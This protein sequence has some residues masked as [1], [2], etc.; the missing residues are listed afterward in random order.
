MKLSVCVL[1]A[2]KSPQPMAELSI[3]WFR[4]LCH[5]WLGYA[6]EA[7]VRTQEYLATG[8]YDRGVGVFLQR[9]RGQ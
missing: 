9:I 5:G 2:S 3:N 6:P 8:R 1:E 4:G 7:L